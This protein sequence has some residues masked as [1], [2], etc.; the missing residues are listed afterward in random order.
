MDVLMKHEMPPAGGE[1]IEQN[2]SRLRVIHAQPGGSVDAAIASLTGALLET[3]GVLLRGFEAL[4][5][6]GLNRVAALLGEPL[7]A[8]EFGS[9]PRTQVDKSVFSSTEYPASQWI[10]Q[11]NEQSY[12]T[13]WPSRILFYCETPATRQGQTPIA[14]SREVY[15]RLD[16]ALRRLFDEK[17]I[18][19]VR[20]Y[21]NGLDVPWQQVFGTD[22]HAEVERFCRANRIGFEWFDDGEALRTR[23]ICQS[24]LRH[25]VTGETVWFNQAHLFHVTNLPADTR[26]AL[27]ELVDEAALPR[28]TYFGDGTPI[29]PQMLDEIRGVYRETT[30][31]FDWQAADLLILDNLLMSHGRAPFEGKRRVLVAMAA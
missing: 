5:A 24:Q 20:N 22:E 27:L 28:N 6:S 12:T 16:P 11:H 21:G 25:P 7:Q 19:Y 31:A 23:Q 17:Q 18:M 29:D 4:G 10:E 9:S 1:L 8:Y 14:D 3:G 30:L 2:G 15:R 26:E 13:K